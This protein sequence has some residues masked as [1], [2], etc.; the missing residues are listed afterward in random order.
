MQNKK[1]AVKAKSKNQ[2][3]KDLLKSKAQD[4]N[5]VRCAIWLCLSCKIGF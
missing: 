1:K 4:S 2:L 3:I 5:S